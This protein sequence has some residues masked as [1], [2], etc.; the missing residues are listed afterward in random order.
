MYRVIAILLSVLVGICTAGINVRK[1]HNV[2]E[3]YLES[4]VMPR[5]PKCYDSSQP[6]N[7]N[8]GNKRNCIPNLPRH[9][10][11][12][13]MLCSHFKN[14]EAFLAE[15]VSYYKVH[16]FE[17]IVFWDGNSTDNFRTE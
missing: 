6:V 17:R 12:K 13:I 11:K 1:T 14:E 5:I 9:S 2:M 7:K 4:P 16:G 10:M 8:N 3:N 15:F